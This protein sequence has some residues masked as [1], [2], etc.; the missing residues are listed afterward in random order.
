MACWHLPSNNRYGVKVV[1]SFP[2][3]FWILESAIER[4]GKAANAAAESAEATKRRRHTS[5]TLPTVIL[6]VVKYLP[7]P[8]LRFHGVVGAVAAFSTSLEKTIF[9]QKL[10][11]ACRSFSPRT[12]IRVEVGK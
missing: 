8:S 5:V 6:L 3:I 1:I 10:G 2:R 12:D 4:A 11:P 7:D 9:N